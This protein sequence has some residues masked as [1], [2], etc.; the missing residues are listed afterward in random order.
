VVVAVALLGGDQG[1]RLRVENVEEDLEFSRHGHPPRW[2][3]LA[4]SLRGKWPVKDFS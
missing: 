1:V 4:R 2:G 3:K